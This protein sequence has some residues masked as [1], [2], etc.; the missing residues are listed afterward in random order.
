[1]LDVRLEG[2]GR[3]DGTDEGPLDAVRV[4]R[5]ARRDER[6]VVVLGGVAQREAPCAH[7]EK[8]QSLESCALSRASPVA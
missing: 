6:Q 8:S 3:S 7:D 1:M 5:R 2:R 4:E